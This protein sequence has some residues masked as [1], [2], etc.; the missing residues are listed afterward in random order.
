MTIRVAITN[1]VLT[2][3]GDAAILF[4]IAQSLE[5]EFGAHNLDIVVLDMN[6]RHSRR[7][8]PG[9]RVVQQSTYAPSSLPRAARRVGTLIKRM[10]AAALSRPGRVSDY[11]M[12]KLDNPVV[13]RV[14]PGWAALWRADI[15]VSSGGTYLVDHYNFAPRVDELVLAHRFGRPVVMWTQSM[16]PFSSS[17]AK[18]AIARLVAVVDACFLRDERSLKSWRDVGGSLT[19][20]VAPDAVFGLTRSGKSLVHQGRTGPSRV[21]F[22]NRRWDRPIDPLR[23]FEF[24]SYSSALRDTAE[25]LA[26]IGNSCEALSTCQGVPGY[27]IDDSETSREIFEGLNVNVD[28]GHHTPEELLGELATADLVIATRMHMA[29]L[30]LIAGRAVIA[31][32]YEFKTLELFRSLGLGRNVVAIEDLD[33]DWLISRAEEALSD[34]STFVLSVDEREELTATAGAPA[35]LCRQLLPV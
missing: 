22:A 11:V 18:G 24:G 29:I 28:G 23:R 30:S 7:L 31:I 17:R 27:S 2:N 9:L 13:Q 35:T 4:A 19:A 1:A 26:S 12:S 20:T 32:A 10:G 34:P 3:T 8:Y 6:A 25:H 33:A 15:V 5:R 21:I 14:T 16:G